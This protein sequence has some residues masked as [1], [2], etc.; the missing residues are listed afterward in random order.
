M[1]WRPGDRA[2]LQATHRSFY[3]VAL[4]QSGKQVTVIA[5]H[6]GL[7]RAVFIFAKGVNL[8]GFHLCFPDH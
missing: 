8:T 3:K 5:P 1:V 7:L 6:I 2:T 4:T